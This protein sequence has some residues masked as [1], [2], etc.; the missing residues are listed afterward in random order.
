MFYLLILEV[1]FQ[2]QESKKDVFFVYP[3][4]PDL[5][6]ITFEQ[7]KRNVNLKGEKRGTH[8][9]HLREEEQDLLE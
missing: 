6:I 3:Q 7:I 9:F 2:V 8:F 1:K 5:S 4:I